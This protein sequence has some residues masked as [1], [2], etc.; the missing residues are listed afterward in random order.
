MEVR[1]SDNKH[2]GKND[3]H[4][5][6]GV[7]FIAMHIFVAINA[8]QGCENSYA[9]YANPARNRTIAQCSNELTAN[10]NV[11]RRPTNTSSNVKEGHND[12]SHPTKGK[13]GYCH[14]A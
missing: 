8:D 9:E 13:A 2:D 11:D 4:R 7:A 3:R 1:S 10:N 5:Y 14:L 6:P 12:R